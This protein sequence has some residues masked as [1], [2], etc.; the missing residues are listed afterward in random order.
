MQTIKRQLQQAGVSHVLTDEPLVKY[1][2]W[3]VGGSADLFVYPKSK[4]ELQQTMTVL[5]REGIPWHAI[6]RGSNLLVRDNGIRGAVIK[7]GE[8]LDHLTI[9]GT[10][11]TAGGGYSFVRLAGK[12]AKAGLSGLEFAS[13]IPGNVGGAVF[14]NAGAHGSDVSRTLVSAEVILEDGSFKTLS[15]ADL[16]F[17][18]RTTA[19]QEHVHGVVAEATFALKKGN[20]AQIMADVR[21]FKQ[22]RNRTQPLNHP[23]AGSVFRN[24]PG[25][26][27]GRLI[28]AAGLKGYRVGDAEVSTLHANFIVNNGKATAADILTLIGDVQKT[29]LE[30]YGIV[31]H[32][33]V[34]VV[35]EE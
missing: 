15:A 2:T 24:P 4:R 12:T 5:H 19:L 25:D 10:R 31:L 11:V 1:T 32:P 14:M 13:G 16:N 27:A 28:E 7:V 18:Y 3:R 35:G 23:C 26:H 29:V 34:R 22:R 9:E 21:A 30:T 8:G 6:G 20:P 17:R 33:E